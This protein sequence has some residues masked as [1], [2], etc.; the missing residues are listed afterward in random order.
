MDGKKKQNS[1]IEKTKEREKVQMQ[2][3][4]FFCAS[5]RARCDECANLCN[6]STT[7]RQQSEKEKQRETEKETELK[8]GHAE[9]GFTTHSAR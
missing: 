5:H 3:E 9:I 6:K 8:W 1:R 7:S 2:R 4:G